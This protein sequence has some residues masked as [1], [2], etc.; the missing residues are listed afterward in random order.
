M[1]DSVQGAGSNQVGEG[2]HKTLI[3]KDPK[4]GWGG[5]GVF[6]QHVSHPLSHQHALSLPQTKAHFSYLGKT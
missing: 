1:T 3:I 5:R 2:Q 6:T 4:S